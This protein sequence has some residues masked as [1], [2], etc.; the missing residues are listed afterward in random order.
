MSY[1]RLLWVRGSGSL[2]WIWD[3]RRQARQW[4]GCADSGHSQGRDLGRK[5]RPFGVMPPLSR[6]TRTSLILHRN[7]SFPGR[8]EENWALASAS[9]FSKE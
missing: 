1:E 2:W 6:G 3:L 5:V 4:R 7:R 8:A 9:F